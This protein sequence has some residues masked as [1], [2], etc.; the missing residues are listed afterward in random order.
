MTTKIGSLLV[1]FTLAVT[2]LSAAPAQ[3]AEDEQAC[4][5]EFDS[6]M[7]RASWEPVDWIRDYSEQACQSMLIMCL[8]TYACGDNYCDPNLENSYYC[9]AD[10]H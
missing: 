4:Y 9:P 3:A 10:C 5:T 1:I 8:A 7:E 2:A 6:C